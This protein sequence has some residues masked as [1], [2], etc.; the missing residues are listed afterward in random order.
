MWKPT[1]T[2]LQV[3]ISLQ[4]M[5]LGTNMPYFNEPGYGQA[6]D[7][8][9]NRNYNANV[10]LATVKHAMLSW[11]DDSKKDGIWGVSPLSS[12]LLLDPS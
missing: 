7:N 2:I 9:Q 11:I 3:L 1:S 5:I 6:T 8:Q 4:A 10:S 12:P